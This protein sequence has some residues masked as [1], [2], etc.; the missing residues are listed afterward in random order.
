MANRLLSGLLILSFVGVSYSYDGGHTVKQAKG[1]RS[2]VSQPSKRI[3]TPEK[4]EGI[5]IF[6]N[7]D[8]MSIRLGQIVSIPKE[9]KFRGV[10]GQSV[11]LVYVD[12]ETV[13][14]AYRWKLEIRSKK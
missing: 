9:E 10:W 13:V 6:D 5:V 14:D 3:P 4:N 12:A 7:G 2:V 8:Y 11:D 1:Q